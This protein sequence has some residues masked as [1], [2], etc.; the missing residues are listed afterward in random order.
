MAI[1]VNYK[2]PEVRAALEDA[3]LTLVEH[4]P[5]EM[6]ERISKNVIEK[7]N[8]NHLSLNPNGKPSE[9]FAQLMKMYSKAEAYAYRSA[10][11]NDS[12]I[13][14]TNWVETG[15]EPKIKQV[16]GNKHV[17]RNGNQSLMYKDGDISSIEL[18]KGILAKEDDDMKKCIGMAKNGARSKVKRGGMWSVQKDLKGMPSHKEGGV[19][20]SF[21]NGVV[22]NSK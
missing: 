1:C 11:Y 21:S 10:M 15:V 19:Q 3:V 5:L 14:K 4:A 18:D 16:L 6:V 13:N 2:Q 8:G 20:L 22:I 9:V 7:N 17:N 12:F